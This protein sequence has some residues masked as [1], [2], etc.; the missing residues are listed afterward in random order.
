MM[1][2][3]SLTALATGLIAACAFGA[4]CA[5]GEE[6]R[7]PANVTRALREAAIPAGAVS[8]YVQE[9]GTKWPRLEVND[10]QPMNP[11]S[12]MKLVT[13][14]AAL[15][16]LGPAFTWST[17]AYANG[18]MQGDVLQGDLVLKGGGDPKLTIENLWLFVKNLRAHGL[19][20][21]RGD[22]VIDHSYF[23]AVPYDPSLFDAE[24]L[25][26]YNV[27]PDALLINFKAFRFTFIPDAENRTVGIG[28][29]PASAALELVNSVKGVDGSCGD[30]KERLHAD[31]QANATWA[32]AAFGGAYPFSCGDKIWNVSMLSSTGYAGSVFRQLWEESGGILR[33]TV[34]DG[35]VAPNAKLIVSVDSAQLAEIVRDINKYSNNVMA[36]QLY[37][38]LSAE[39]AHAPGSTTRS[40]K[41]VDTWLKQHDLDFRELSIENGS[42]LS[43]SDR[44]SAQH[45]G[46]LLLTAFASPVMPE[47]LASL[48]LVATDGTMKK[49]LNDKTVAGQAHIKT[50][51]LEGVKGIAGYVLD[52]NGKLEIVVFMI[53]HAN[54]AAGQVAQ[55]AFLQWVYEAG[56]I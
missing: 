23:E 20:E 8:A 26:P 36:R 10:K 28:V 47:Y 21:V 1:L 55:D 25:R 46:Q 50:G 48:P 5:F 30:W 37:L 35:A 38:T 49:R 33:G 32:K 24:P 52:K 41:V 43:R 13:T 7:L 29:E 40:A 56:G 16:L 27:G 51:T 53:N 14:Y 6:L 17:S 39:L 11:A 42:G 34:R 19:R 4:P 18:S 12:L 31:F 15:D 45:L 54:A 44:I 9:I 3:D 22:L 2:R